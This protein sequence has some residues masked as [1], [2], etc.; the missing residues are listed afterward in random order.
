MNVHR[1]N[2][3][4]QSERKT[5]LEAEKHCNHCNQFTRESELSTEGDMKVGEINQ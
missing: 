4:K 2:E 3:T 1:E 5:M